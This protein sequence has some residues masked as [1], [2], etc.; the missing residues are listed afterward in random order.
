MDCKKTVR[1]INRFLE[2]DLETEELQDFLDH[3]KT[4]EECNEELTIA[5]LVKEGVARLENGS[6]FDLQ[7][8][9]DTTINKADHSLRIREGMQW[10]YYLIIGLIVVAITF[11][12][13]ILVFL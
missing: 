5:F 2:D 11:L 8:E 4:C 1:L 7:K 13:L 12:I 10:V 6:V 9:L 3:V